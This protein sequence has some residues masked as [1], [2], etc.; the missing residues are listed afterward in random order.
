MDLMDHPSIN[1]LIRDAKRHAPILV[2]GGLALLILVSTAVALAVSGP[3]PAGDAHQVAAATSPSRAP[4]PSAS[5]A[6]T[7][8][9]TPLPAE[10]APASPSV[11]PLRTP[12]PTAKPTDEPSSGDWIDTD[13][14]P[15]DEY[16]GYDEE[17]IDVEEPAYELDPQM[18]LL[19]DGKEGDASFYL[20]TGETFAAVLQFPTQDLEESDCSLTESYEPDDP[21]GT[22]W[23]VS[24]E[25]VP[26]QSVAM[27]DG[28]HTFVATCATEMGPISAMVRGIVM[29]QKAEACRDFEFARDE[30]SV[31]TL[32][33][34][35]SGVVGTWKGC[36][37]TR[38]TPMYEVTVTLRDDGTYSA[39]TT[40]VLDGSPM[41][42][43]YYGTDDDYPSKVYALN[44]LQDSLLG[45]GQID[46]AFGP[47]PAMRDG[48]RNVRLM[49][50]KL[51]FE[52]FHM[53]QYGPITFQLYRAS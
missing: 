31:S 3:T 46:L 44:D 19:I 25:P 51:E 9:G 32:E 53:E 16:P 6:P 26:V 42:A 11:A 30:I 17:P 13:P 27:A 4:T 5:P 40:E 14:V 2:F 10:P 39:T 12:D 21:K 28:R 50:D 18:N 7:A 37:T 48:L 35:T 47:E 34:L 20:P 45:V 29:D 41:V 1:R 33:E 15:D 49:G 36:V 43:M 22:P 24:L 52:L 38:W 23:T 8:S